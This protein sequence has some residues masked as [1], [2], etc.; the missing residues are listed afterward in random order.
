MRAFLQLKFRNIAKVREDVPTQFPS[1]KE[2]HIVPLKL[3]VGVSRKIG[4]PD[5][6]SVGASCNLE[7]EL[8]ASLIE[9]D[10]DSFQARVRDVYVAAQQAVNDELARLHTPATP[11]QEPPVPAP[12][13]RQSHGQANGNGHSHRPLA[14][15]SR[16]DKPA[17][18]N[19]VKAIRSIARRQN[20][21]LEGLLRD[22]YGVVRP[23]DLTLKQASA[24]IDMLKAA[25]QI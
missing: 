16:A 21:D 4:L 7:L 17:T 20:A 18:E 25:G 9:R 13:S 12:A 10:L 2:E 23:E 24:F 22:E 5:Y 8:D 15:R 3:N 1:R 19:Q 14:G 6:G 11:P